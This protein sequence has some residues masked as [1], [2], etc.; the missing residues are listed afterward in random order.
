MFYRDYEN[1]N[2]INI[3]YKKLNNDDKFYKNINCKFYYF[4]F[5]TSLSTLI[6]LTAFIIGII[7]YTSQ[8]NNI[9][10]MF[11]IMDNVNDKQVVS[12]ITHTNSFINEMNITYDSIKDSYN[13]LKEVASTFGSVDDMT[14][15][16]ENIRYLVNHA[17]YWL[18]CNDNIINNSINISNI[19]N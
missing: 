1:D 13:E 16:I 2:N 4:V 19:I 15:F 9:T 6:I 10:K 17:C 11:Y 12:L 7:S 8:K 14:V 5:I 3:N 18:N